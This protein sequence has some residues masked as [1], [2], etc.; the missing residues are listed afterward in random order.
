MLVNIF[1]T[2]LLSLWLFSDF[3]FANTMADFPI[4]PHTQVWWV[5]H[6]NIHNGHQVF[7]KKFKSQQTP[8]KLSDFYQ[9]AWQSNDDLPGYMKTDEAG[10]TMIS[11]LMPEYQWV[12]QI[13]SNTSGSGSEGYL[14]AMKLTGSSALSKLSKPFHSKFTE[15][16][17]GGDLLSSTESIKPRLARTQLHLYPQSPGRVASQFKSHMAAK[18]WSLQDEYSHQGTVT[19]RFEN[20]KRQIDLAIVSHS[21]GKTLVFLNEVQDYE[22]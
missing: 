18:G 17:R 12:V 15:A 20:T 13:R 11:R 8:E 14:S 7:I 6:G 2:I 5:T 22:K 10:W 1:K 4:P 3:V 9:R 16:I 21:G 19:Q